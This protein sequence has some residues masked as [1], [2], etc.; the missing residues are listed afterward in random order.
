[1]NGS[2]AH[3][4][5]PNGTTVN[6][7]ETRGRWTGK[8]SSQVGSSQLG[9][10]ELKTAC[11][12]IRAVRLLSG[13]LLD[14]ALSL[15]QGRLRG[16]SPSERQARQAAGSQNHRNCPV[17]MS[18]TRRWFKSTASHALLACEIC[19]QEIH[20]KERRDTSMFEPHPAFVVCVQ[21]M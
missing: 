21:R 1:M 11:I 16:L 12:I 13:R 18:V 7:F 8:D 17:M 14:L 10:L 6:P 9:H 15:L 19:I 5:L 2:A 20:W 3:D 4:M